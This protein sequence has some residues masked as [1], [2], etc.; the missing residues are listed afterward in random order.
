MPLIIR[1][2]HIKVAVN[3]PAEQG[4]RATAPAAAQAQGGDDD[5]KEAI[6]AECVEQVMEI[7]RNRLEP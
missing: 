4:G 3:A 7:L 6:V 1:E 5:D 2:L